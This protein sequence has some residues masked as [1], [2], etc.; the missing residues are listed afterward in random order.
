MTDNDLLYELWTEIRET[1]RQ[2]RQL[3]EIVIKMRA[4]M[5]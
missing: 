1:N 5:K 4:E 2:M 3:I